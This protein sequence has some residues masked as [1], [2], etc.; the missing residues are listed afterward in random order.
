MEKYNRFLPLG[1]IVKVKELKNPLMIIKNKVSKDIDY[2]GI[3]HP[4]GFSEDKNIQKFNIKDI[5]EVYF[6]GYQ[7]TIVHNQLRKKN[8]EKILEG[9]KNDRS[10]TN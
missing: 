4:L 7:N 8:I 9:D 5:E 1:S 10:T 2:Y 6:T 3:N